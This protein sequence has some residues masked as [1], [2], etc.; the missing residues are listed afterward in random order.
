MDFYNKEVLKPR[1]PVMLG[2][3]CWWPQCEV[4]HSAGYQPQHLVNGALG[5]IPAAFQ[6]DPNRYGEFPG[7]AWRGDVPAQ[8]R[9]VTV[10]PTWILGVS[11]AGGGSV[12]CGL[13][14]GWAVTQQRWFQRLQAGVT[15]PVTAAA[16]SSPR[17][18]VQE[19]QHRSG[20]SGA[21]R[22]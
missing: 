5:G 2:A 22:Q 14:L 18:E 11:V 17:Q 20:G 12:M 1:S 7:W 15:R 9:E 3:G 6:W 4:C 19:Q 16:S 8:H 21:G 10:P 13:Q